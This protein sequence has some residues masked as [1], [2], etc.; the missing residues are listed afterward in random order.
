[1]SLLITGIIKP[2]NSPLLIYYVAE[3]VEI[4]MSYLSYLKI[5]YTIIKKEHVSLTK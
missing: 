1:M 3:K 4:V 5:K 2:I